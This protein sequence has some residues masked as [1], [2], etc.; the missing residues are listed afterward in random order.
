MSMNE[1]IKR[2]LAFNVDGEGKDRATSGNY[3]FRGSVFYY[4]ASPAMRIVD[5]V[6]KRK[7]VLI[8]HVGLNATVKKPYTD[9]QLRSLNLPD[10]GVFS[11]YEGDMMEDGHPLN[12]RVRFILLSQLRAFVQEEIVT[13]NGLELGG[14]GKAGKLREKAKG[15]YKIYNTYREWIGCPWPNMPDIYLQQFDE[16]VKRKIADYESPEAQKKRERA[17]ARKKASKMLGLDEA[18]TKAA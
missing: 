9:K 6:G 1:V 17:A 10:I 8:R 7:I 18:A 3:W 14:K 15:F 13:I 11:S 2:W 16:T 12:E 4:D 5:G